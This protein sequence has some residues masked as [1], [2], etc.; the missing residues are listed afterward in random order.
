MEAANMR[1]LQAAVGA[2]EGG[3]CAD[4]LES[5]TE[6]LEGGT[7]SLKSSNWSLECLN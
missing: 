2:F 3:A 1:A 6:G 4:S 5:C 7:D